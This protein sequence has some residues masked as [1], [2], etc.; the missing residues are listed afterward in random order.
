MYNV[1]VVTHPRQVV[2][3]LT[4]HLP[5]L[6]IKVQKDRSGT[7]NIKNLGYEHGMLYK[8]SHTMTA[9]LLF[10]NFKFIEQFYYTCSH[11][12]ISVKEV[13]KGSNN[14]DVNILLTQND[15]I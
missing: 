11:P 5:R 13:D 3:E 12:Y 1:H 15:F 4:R 7:C 10:D 6:Y 14:L 2:Q 9:Y 8:G